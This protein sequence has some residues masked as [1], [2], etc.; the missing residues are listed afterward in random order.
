LAGASGISTA[1]DEKTAI[2]RCGRIAQ[3]SH[4]TISTWTESDRYFFSSGN[5]GAIDLLTNRRQQDRAVVDRPNQKGDDRYS[6]PTKRN[7]IDNGKT[8]ATSGD[9]LEYKPAIDG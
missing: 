6:K 4:Q 3:F 1:F 8:P 7:H 9:D 2:A 5:K